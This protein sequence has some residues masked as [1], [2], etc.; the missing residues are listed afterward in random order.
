MTV[1]LCGMGIG[2]LLM[3]GLTIGLAMFTLW[4]GRLPGLAGT[5]QAKGPEPAGTNKGGQG[6]PPVPDKKPEPDMSD[7][8]A[9]EVAV[10]PYGIRPPK[11]YNLS[12]LP[13]DSGPGHRAYVWMLRI[14][15]EDT[16]AMLKVL[17][18]RPSP[19]FR[20]PT[21]QQTYERYEDS[22]RPQW[23]EFQG[24]S[25]APTRIGGLDFLRG[26]WT[27][28]AD[29]PGMR[30]HGI[31]YTAYDLPYAVQIRCEVKTTLEARLKP[32]EAAA[33]TFRKP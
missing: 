30:M 25:L 2:L 24:R 28:R 21:L 29:G 17:I 26:Q 32:M 7:K 12:P 10:G 23:E 8:L 14:E 15:V 33:L 20:W 1:L 9:S 19:E 3:M 11:G 5:P 6:D 27:A 4:P 31:C 16:R 22:M 13:E 18:E